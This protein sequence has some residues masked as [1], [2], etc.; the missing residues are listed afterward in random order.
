MKSLLLITAS[1]ALTAAIASA[2][3][4]NVTS[5]GVGIGTPT[6]MG[7]LDVGNVFYTATGSITVRPETPTGGPEGGQINLEGSSGWEGT[8]V[9][10]YAGIMRFF[11]RHYLFYTS[12]ASGVKNRFV[13]TNEGSV[14]VGVENP[15]EK[16]HVGGG[17]KADRFIV[18]SDQ[19]SSNSY[20]QIST[21]G[22]VD[23]QSPGFDVIEF[24]PNPAL[25]SG[26]SWEHFKIF[27]DGGNVGL[28]TTGT[29][30]LAVNGG[31]VGIGTT[32][33]GRKLD[34]AGTAS[35]G[36]TSQD[37]NPTG[38]N[39]NYTL[40]LNAVDTSSIGFHDAWNSVSSIRYNGGGFTI[41]GDDGWGARNVYMPGNVGIGTTNPTHKLTVN[42]LVK[43][44]G[45]VT[46]N[47]NWADYVF[48]PEYALAPLSDVEAHI[49]EKGHLPG[50]PSAAEVKTAG[51]VE[52][53]DMQVRLL[54]KVEEL[55]LHLI[56]MEKQIKAQQML[57]EQLRGGSQ[58]NNTR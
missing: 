39:W 6:P 15:Q 57:I 8:A 41:G 49:K 51:G 30:I 13:I 29:T 58:P 56:A 42:G 35:I 47:G 33:P 16:M 17:F 12:S 24:A 4:I 21:S 19:G 26:A 44:R 43:S 32:A 37:Y 1:A 55:T 7:A 10:N 22:Y 9:D 5:S 25:L 48:K 2:Q 36:V 53:G 34:V 23:L 54:G 52:I 28:Q 50:I 40:L 27:R 46:D 20:L 31:N 45:F 3:P 38:G 14:G 11:G 18:D